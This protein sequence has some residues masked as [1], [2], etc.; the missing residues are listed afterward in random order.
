MTKFRHLFPSRYFCVVIKYL[1]LFFASLG[2][3][4]LLKILLLITIFIFYRAF[5]FDLIEPFRL[6]QVL[7]NVPCLM[8][9]KLIS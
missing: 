6:W 1:P 5:Y 8:A 2:F 7:K 9:F 3:L 4:V